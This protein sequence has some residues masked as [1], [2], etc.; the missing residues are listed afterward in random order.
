[1]AL[2]PRYVP[3]VFAVLMSTLM[4]FIMSG[5]ITILNTGFDAG[6]A[7]RWAI[8]FVSAWPV[9]FFCVMFFAGK[10]R[11]LALKICGAEVK[12]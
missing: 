8:A 7:K 2:T 3:I 12:H 10:V 6:L 1:M 11:A 4:V 9:A 5:F